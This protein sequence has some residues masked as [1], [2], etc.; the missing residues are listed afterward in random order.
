M[1]FFYL[2]LG[3]IFFLFNTSYAQKSN[4][5]RTAVERMM[6]E[7]LRGYPLAEMQQWQ[8]MHPGEPL[9][10]HL[11]QYPNNAASDRSGETVVSGNP[12]A[13]SEVH[14]AINPADSAN[15]IVSGIVQDP[16]NLFSPL[17][18]PVRYTTN[19]GQTWQTS[20][21]DFSPGTGFALVA[22][23]GDPV[24]AFDKAGNAYLSWLVLTIDILSTPPVKLALYVSKSTNKGATWGTPVLIDEGKV[25]LEVLTGGAGT[26]DLVD[27]QWMA[28][29]QT[30]GANEGALYVAYTRF[31]I[32]DS[33]TSTAQILLRKKAKTST[34]FTTPSVQVHTNNYGIVQFSSIAIDA[35]GRVHVT[36]FAG[37]STTD[38][39]IYHAVSTDGGVSFAPETKISDVY[40]PRLVGGTSLDSIAGISGDRLYPCPHVATGKTPGTL[41]CTWTANGLSS[42]QTAGY[43]IWFS[44]STNNGQTWSAPV[45]INPGPDEEAHQFYA[46]LYV[47][48][49]GTL[50][51]SYYDRSDDPTGT[52]TDYVITVSE[53]DGATFSTAQK[54][55]STP[56]DFSKIGDLNAGFG[57]GEYTQVI[58]TDYF[59]IPV[60]A[61][62]RSNDGDI[63]LYAAF[64]PLSNPASSTFEWSNLSDAFGVTIV[65]PAVRSANI[66]VQ[67]KKATPVSV[68]IFALNGRTVVSDIQNNTLPEGRIERRYPLA[69]GMYMCKIT[70]NFGSVVRKIIVGSEK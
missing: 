48:N 41:F 18:V 55:S 14:A 65:N 47:N 44:K 17:D 5:V 54:A 63:D 38:M 29:D 70:T 59:A 13:E 25:P 6:G 2:T 4:F 27:K 28:V 53:D 7:K 21:V 10:G 67:L 37:N 58:C 51:I 23:G 49:T 20:T 32:L 60:W 56:S 11:W 3:G 24:I 19:F 12:E 1:R 52:S 30:T 39:G 62:G 15:I 33:V 8:L 36:F 9:P 35:A 61:D 66:A 34:T 69:A 31:E 26:G 40:F 16:S 50:C 22:G 68:E 43:D 46:S 42:A 57:I 64:I 45:R